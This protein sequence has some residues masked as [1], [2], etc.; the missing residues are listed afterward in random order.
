MSLLSY[1]NR[2]QAFR[3]I[4]VG[5]R[6][7]AYCIYASRRFYKPRLPLGPTTSSDNPDLLRLVEAVTELGVIPSEKGPDNSAS[8]AGWAAG[9]LFAFIDSCGSASKL[10]DDM[11]FD[12]L[13]CDD[14]G[15]EIADFIGLDLTNGRVVAIH[16]KAFKVAKP[17]SASALQE[18]SAQALKNLGFL[19]PYPY[20]T[21]P[22][23][24]R[25]SRPWRSRAGRVT[26][27]V[28]RGSGTPNHLWNQFREALIDPQ[29]TREVWIMMGQGPSQARLRE[30]SRKAQPK[31]EV[32]QML[33]SLQ[34][35]WGAVSSVGARLRVLSSP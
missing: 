13:V 4:P 25:W 1:L 15:T 31:A 12:V 10:A 21:P 16:A 33:F 29:V 27:R 9:S 32:I 30:E 19:Q 7:A 34:A 35:T 3:V 20:G 2:E 17:L 8:E 28:R 22:N 5:G 6:G 24:Q 26:S 23:L 14:G 11:R 18:V